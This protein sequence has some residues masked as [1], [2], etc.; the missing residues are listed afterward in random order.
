MLYIVKREKKIKKIGKYLPPTARHHSISLI[1]LSSYPLQPS[2]SSVAGFFLPRRSS[3]VLISYAAQFRRK[4][5]P[6]KHLDWIFFPRGASSASPP[7]RLLYLSLSSLPTELLPRSAPLCRVSSSSPS[8][9]S[10]RA[11][12]SPAERSLCRVRLPGSPAPHL[13]SRSRTPMARS[14]LCARAVA[15]ISCSHARQIPVLE[16]LPVSRGFFLPCRAPTLASR[17]QPPISNGAGPSLPCFSLS[18]LCPLARRPIHG[19]PSRTPVH[20]LGRELPCFRDYR[21]SRCAQV[22]DDVVESRSVVAR[23]PRRRD[24]GAGERRAAPRTRLCAWL[25]LVESPAAPSQLQLDP[26]LRAHAPAE[27]RAR[28]PHPACA[29]TAPSLPVLADRCCPTPCCARPGRRRRVFRCLRA[30]A[31]VALGCAQCSCRC[32]AVA[33]AVELALLLRRRSSVAHA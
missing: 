33:N 1:Q 29:R 15:L 30:I 27:L 14:P 12:R 20:L 3:A 16:P 22:R 5:P 25:L 9:F 24:S 18:S 8:S 13:L 7:V 21:S 19:V 26:F 10:S 23:V 31:Q 6:L 17:A 4:I 28:A 11:A 2:T 32:C